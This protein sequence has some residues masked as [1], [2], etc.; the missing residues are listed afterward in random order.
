[1]YFLCRTEVDQNGFLPRQHVCVRAITF[2][3]DM[4]VRGAGFGGVC[5][6]GEGVGLRKGDG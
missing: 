5:E 6:D 1:M 2:S 4:M 3:A